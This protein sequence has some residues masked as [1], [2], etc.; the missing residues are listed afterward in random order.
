MVRNA[1]ERR[2]PHQKTGVYNVYTENYIGF[3]K[4]WGNSHL[5][6]YKPWVESM[7][8]ISERQPLSHRALCQRCIRN[9][10]Q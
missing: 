3:L 10:L 2:D 4:L 7:G 6:L 1:E 8:E 9:S 5:K